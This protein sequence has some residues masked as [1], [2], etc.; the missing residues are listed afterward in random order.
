MILKKDDL[1]KRRKG[2]RTRR[3]FESS[4]ELVHVRKHPRALMENL[5]SAPHHPQPT[6]FATRTISSSAPNTARASSSGTFKLSDIDDLVSCIL[7]KNRFDL[8]LH[9]PKQLSCTHTTCLQCLHKQAFAH[10]T[11]RCP[12]PTCGIKMSIPASLVSEAFP[13]NV[14]PPKRC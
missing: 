8:G 1:G 9:L 13:T 14:L 6:S 3:A 7:C 2:E 10:S 12:I 11:I 5:Q 4:D